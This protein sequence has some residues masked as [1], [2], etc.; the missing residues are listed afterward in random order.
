VFCVR[1]DGRHGSVLSFLPFPTFLKEKVH[2]MR[3]KNSYAAAVA[4][5]VSAVVFSAAFQPAANATPIVI[6][7]FTNQSSPTTI[8][9]GTAAAT[10]A[11]YLSTPANGTA[12]NA[13]G[14][15]FPNR[16]FNG[17]AVQV[18]FGPSNSPLQTIS[19]TFNTTTGTSLTMV[20]A[21][22][23]GTVPPAD[24]LQNYTSLVYSNAAPVNLAAVGFVPGNPN[25]KI[26]IKKSAG[27]SS[28]GPFTGQIVINTG[29]GASLSY[30]VPRAD[31]YSNTQLDIPLSS[32]FANGITDMANVNSITLTS[33]M[34]LQSANDS[35]VVRNA[36]Y[37]NSVTFTEVSIVPEPTHMVFVAG[38]GAALGAWR[39][40]KLR[41]SRTAAGD[42]IAG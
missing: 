34:D 10:G 28:T 25:A 14:S 13:S 11:T 26:T 32:F 29:T 39:L 19:G 27:N 22:S 35:A 6:D 8:A 41:R 3:F 2:F 4:A 7:S 40:R 15:L 36:A 24:I 33:L 5:A 20:N 18:F 12:G 38:I 37:S 21:K 16:A 23:A 31:W 30:S 42:A 1:G 17:L 9:G